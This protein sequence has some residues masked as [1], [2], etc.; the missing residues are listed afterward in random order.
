MANII[1]PFTRIPSIQ[2]GCTRICTWEP[3]A[4]VKKEY[5]DVMRMKTDLGGTHQG[6]FYLGHIRHW[7]PCRRRTPNTGRGFPL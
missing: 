4:G 7:P 5:E 3:G 6:T 1:K 2:S